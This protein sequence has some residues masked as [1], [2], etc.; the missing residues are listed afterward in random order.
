[1]ARKKLGLRVTDSEF[2]TLSTP[3]IKL[4]YLANPLLFMSFT[5]E[6]WRKSSLNLLIALEYC[7]T[8]STLPAVFFKVQKQ[9]GVLQDA[10]VTFTYNTSQILK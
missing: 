3:S 4:L 2:S 6:A 10:K 5:H 9:F 1:M 7:Y 8:N